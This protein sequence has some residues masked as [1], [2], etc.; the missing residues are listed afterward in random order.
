MPG[1]VVAGRVERF[2]DGADAAVHH[3]ARR[4]QIGPGGSVGERGLHEQLDAFVVQDMEM[5]AVDPGDAAM[6]VAH[7]FAKTDIGN[8]EQLGA[9][10]LDRADRLLHDA[11]LSIRAGSGFILFGGNAEEEDGLQAGGRAR[12]ASA[13][14]S[15][16]ASWST[17]GMLLM[18]RRALIFSFTK[19]GR[20]KSCGLRLVSR[21]RLR[22]G[23]VRRRRRGR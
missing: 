17:P 5:V 10:G 22:S 20:M 16:G 2:A 9:F 14:I 12:A 7:V 23:A 19:S 15:F 3:V 18:A 6:A 13:A 21:T 1:L 11:I 8:D 4:D